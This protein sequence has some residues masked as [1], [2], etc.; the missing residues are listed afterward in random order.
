MEQNCCYALPI[1]RVSYIGLG[2]GSM[3]GQDGFQPTAPSLDWP[4]LL[5]GSSARLGFY[6]RV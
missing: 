2:L 3:E 5:E 4:A 6:A 1:G